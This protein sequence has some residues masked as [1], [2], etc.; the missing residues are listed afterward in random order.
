M[1]L[2]VPI[3][4]NPV[5]NCLEEFLTVFQPILASSYYYFL[6]VLFL[7]LKIPYF[8]MAEKQKNI[9]EE[10]G[11]KTKDIYKVTNIYIYIC[12]SLL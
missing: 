7:L 2:F 1:A 4:E 5:H 9:E 8:C 10:K 11:Q 12:V 6:D 3:S